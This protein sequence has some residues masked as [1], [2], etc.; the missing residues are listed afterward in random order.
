MLLSSSQWHDIHGEMNVCVCVWE[1]GGDGEKRDLG[2]EM[3]LIHCVFVVS[4]P[5]PWC[6]SLW[7]NMLVR[8]RNRWRSQEN[9]ASPK[10]PF[11]FTNVSHFFF[12]PPY[13]SFPAWH[14]FAIL[15][16]E[17]KLCCIFS[18][19]SIP[20]FTF[21]ISLSP[22]LL[23]LRSQVASRVR[24]GF[25]K[26][27]ACRRDTVTDLIAERERRAERDGDKGQTQYE[28]PFPEIFELHLVSNIFLFSIHYIYTTHYS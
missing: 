24:A 23:L 28:S 17:C 14:A 18:F 25:V 7:K 19:F 13:P 3:A 10:S 27:H 22:M 8:Q 15:E 20:S 12:S 5:L 2:S 21:L 16:E 4:P 11:L 6:T 26:A 1:K 9:V